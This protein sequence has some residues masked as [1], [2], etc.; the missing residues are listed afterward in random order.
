MRKPFKYPAILCIP[1][2]YPAT[3][4]QH[5]TTQPQATEKVKVSVALF[6]R[7]LVIPVTIILQ[8][9]QNQLRFL[10]LFVDN[11]LRISESPPFVGFL[12]G[13]L[14]VDSQICGGGGASLI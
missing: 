4:F 6:D 8:P 14:V 7:W 3:Q 5:N 9:M 13:A 2:K 12:I 1:F 11:I 10:I